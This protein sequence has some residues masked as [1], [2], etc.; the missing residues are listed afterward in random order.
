MIRFYIELIIEKVLYVFDWIKYG[1]SEAG[2]KQRA[3]RDF[4]RVITR[5]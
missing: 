5:R 2:K 3:A 1:N 4:I